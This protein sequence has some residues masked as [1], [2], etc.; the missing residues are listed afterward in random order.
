[1]M[2]LAWHWDSCGQTRPQTAG[3]AFFDFMIA[4]PSAYFFSFTHFMN[5]GIGTSTGQPVTHCGFGHDRHRLASS[6]ASSS[7]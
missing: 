4:M 2:H 6:N 5:V 3:S 7:L 1:M